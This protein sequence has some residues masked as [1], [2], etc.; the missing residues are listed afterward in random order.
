MLQCSGHCA[1]C[2]TNDGC[3]HI[4]C[5]CCRHYFEIDTCVAPSQLAHIIAPIHF[6]IRSGFIHGCIAHALNILGVGLTS[7]PIASTAAEMEVENISLCEDCVAT[8]PSTEVAIGQE[9]VSIPRLQQTD[10]DSHRLQARDGLLSSRAQSWASSMSARSRATERA[11]KQTPILNN[12]GYSTTGTLQVSQSTGTQQSSTL[13]PH[14][15]SNE[16]RQRRHTLANERSTSTCVGAEQRVE[17]QLSNIEEPPPLYSNLFPE[18]TVHNAANSH[19][20]THFLP[21]VQNNYASP[22]HSTSLSRH[23]PCNHHIPLHHCSPGYPFSHCS[24][25]TRILLPGETGRC[26]QDTTQPTVRV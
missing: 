8:E 12:N 16:T 6:V 17:R 7:P 2:H 24:H 14:G 5:G 18:T 15:N 21:S 20:Q 4:C 10:E 11:S 22:H 26:S 9:A 19:A 25:H 23:L 3:Y 1:P 13:T